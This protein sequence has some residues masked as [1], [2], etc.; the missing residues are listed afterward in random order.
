[1]ECAGF[2]LRRQAIFFSIWTIVHGVVLLIIL[3]TLSIIQW[4]IEKLKY[5]RIYHLMLVGLSMVHFMSGIL[6]LIGVLKSLKY[7]YIPG[8]ILSFVMPIV[9]VNSVLVYMIIFI[10]FFSTSISLYGARLQISVFCVR[11]EYQNLQYFR[12]LLT[13]C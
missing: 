8:F 11:R 5:K 9:T 10:L 13:N 12:N 4:D 3:G 6:M 1:M 7:I 2:T